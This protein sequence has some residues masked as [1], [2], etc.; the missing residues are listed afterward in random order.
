MQ[1]VEEGRMG[2]LA[3]YCWKEAFGTLEENG[4]RKQPAEG[5]G[6][7]AP[8]G[9]A[10][11]P[12]LTVPAVS[13]PWGEPWEDGAVIYLFPVPP[14]VLASACGRSWSVQ[15]S[16]CGRLGPKLQR[17]PA[18]VIPSVSELDPVES[19]THSTSLLPVG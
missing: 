10:S 11:P 15:V 8:R 13:S 1:K 6:G 19:C 17:M 3:R 9:K 5:K 18:L 16:R 7:K 4:S 2:S 12:S 14:R